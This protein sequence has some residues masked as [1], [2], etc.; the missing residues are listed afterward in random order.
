MAHDILVRMRQPMHITDIIDHI[1]KRFGVHVDRESLVSALTKR[2][3][4]G[5]R[6]ERTD[7]NTFAVRKD[8]GQ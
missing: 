7:R 5:D 3:A 4:R 1:H 8:D 6:F 2:V